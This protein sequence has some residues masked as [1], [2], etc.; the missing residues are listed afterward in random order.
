MKSIIRNLEQLNWKL[1]NTFFPPSSQPKKILFDHLPKCGGSSLNA[2]LIAGFS[3]QKRFT[4][5]GA[6]PSTS[7]EEFKA[8][9]EEIRYEY[10][11]ING[12]LA[13][14]LIEYANPECLK[15]TILREPV[16]RI[17][18]LYYYIKKSEIHF[19]HSKLIE[20]NMSLEEYVTSDLSNAAKNWYTSHFSALSVKHIDQNPKESV[21]KAVDN[22]FSK[23]DIIGLLSEYDAFIQSLKRHANLKT[24]YDN[25]KQNVTEGR[26]TPEEI[27]PTTR[28]TIEEINY[29]DLD[30]YKKVTEKL[31][32]KREQ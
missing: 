14:R 19:L 29:I 10:S 26:P 30:F 17:I 15:V 32:Q 13:N 21:A 5:D 18:S 23:Y 6:N 11:L 12:H 1:K 20:A 9:P 25:I 16:E 8:L 4:I 3:N 31:K 7:V 28:K 2:Y 27:S 22:L 24:K